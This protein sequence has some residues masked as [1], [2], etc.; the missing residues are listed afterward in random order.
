MRGHASIVYHLLEAATNVIHYYERHIMILSEE[1]QKDANIPI[2][3]QQILEILV[4]Y[5]LN[6][7]EQFLTSGKALCREVIKKYAEEGTINVKV[8]VYRGFHVRPST[9]VS[10]IVQ[11]YGSDVYLIIDNEKFDA[12][13]PMNLFRVNEKINAAKRRNLAQNINSLKCVL[14]PECNLN[15]EKGLKEIFHEL[16]EENKIINYAPEF[17]MPEITSIS[18]ETLG[19]FANRAI[20]SLLAQGQIDLKTDLNVTFQGD[21]RVLADIETL[22]SCGYG[23]DAYGNN[24]VLPEHLS[25]L[26][27]S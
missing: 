8:P 10:K 21:K 26:R 18:E 24:I 5:Y 27:K 6:Y 25:Y 14:D 7:S 4:N 11:H 16:L 17:S 20:A 22:A 19:E 13:S 9:L 3:S 15:F 2:S 12:S 1:E 23:E